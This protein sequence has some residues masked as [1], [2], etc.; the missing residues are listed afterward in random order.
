[1]NF[2]LYRASA[3]LNDKNLK[4][5]RISFLRNR[6]ENK[7]VDLFHVNYLS[8]NQIH[9]VFFISDEYLFGTR[10][11]GSH[12]TVPFNQYVNT[13]IFPK[14]GFILV[15]SISK[16]Y[17]EIVTDELNKMF[18]VHFEKITL[19]NNQIKNIIQTINATIK[20]IEYEDDEEGYTLNTPNEILALNDSI[21]NNNNDI[22]YI[23]LKIDN[24]L[25]SIRNKQIISI[26][27]ND[28]DFLIKICGEIIYA[29]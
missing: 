14:T 10:K 11:S 29:I 21:Y 28:E 4:K 15:E 19:N 1:M 8:D 5:R 7:D 20:E 24:N 16:N 18:N 13:F 3:P 12:I 6:S 9:A 26:N 22:Y 17:C 2:Y 27:N 23:L 25:L